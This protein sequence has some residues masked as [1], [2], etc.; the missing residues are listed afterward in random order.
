MVGKSGM[1]AAS[2]LIAVWSKADCS[3]PIRKYEFQQGTAV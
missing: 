1:T 2:V 3:V